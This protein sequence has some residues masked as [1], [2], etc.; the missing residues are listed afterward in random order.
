MQT[1]ASNP[2]NVRVKWLRLLFHMP[3]VTFLL[4]GGG[5]A[6]S[7]LG[8]VTDNMILTVIGGLT[9]G[10]IFWVIN[11]ARYRFIEGDVNISK[12]LSLNPP[13]F[14]TSTN[15]RNTHGKLL[16]PVIKIVRRKVPSARGR[17]FKVG[18]YFPAACLYSGTFEKPHWDNFYP[19]PLSVATDNLLTIDH[20]N[21]DLEYL[22]AEFEARL[23][24]VDTP[25]K[26]GLYFIDEAR[27][28]ARKTRP[29]VPETGG[30]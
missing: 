8:Y 7:Y 28:E 21:E 29:A 13:L 30:E 9:V 3:L 23:S 1:Y 19:V 18:D 2:G 16:F 26:P 11:N 22:R 4:V 12:V 20:H 25:N 5:A 27:L 10:L 14:A 15:M 24:L 17:R 6:I